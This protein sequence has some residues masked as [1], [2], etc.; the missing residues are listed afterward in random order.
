MEAKWLASL[1]QYL[2]HI[3]GAIT[4][5]KNYV[6]QLERVHDIYLMDTILRS[7]QF[8]AEEIRFLNYCRLYLQAVT[9]SDITTATGDYLDSN[10]IQGRKSLSSSD[11]KWHHNVMH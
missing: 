4:L 9:L 1:R 5:D 6:P 10:M 7:Q 11:T 3:N 8:D 2:H